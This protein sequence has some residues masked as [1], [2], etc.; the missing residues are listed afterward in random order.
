[1]PGHLAAAGTARAL[2]LVRTLYAV[3]RDIKVERVR[4]GSTFTDADMV[5]WRHTRAGPILAAFARWLEEHHRSATPKSLFGQAI[6]DARNRWATLVRYLDDVRLAI[7][8][9]AAERAIRPL[10][11]GTIRLAARGR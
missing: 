11:R 8:N 10:G 2:P 1:M 4:P 3:E 5:R 7:D 9:G 6:A